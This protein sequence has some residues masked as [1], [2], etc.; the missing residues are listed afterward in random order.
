MQ[1]FHVAS[2]PLNVQYERNFEIRADLPGMSKSDIKVHVD[3][4]IVT[5]IVEKEDKRD[6][7]SAE[8]GVRSAY[9]LASLQ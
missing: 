4:D 5:V 3:H 1:R 8:Q 2:C 9:F 7:N 6:D